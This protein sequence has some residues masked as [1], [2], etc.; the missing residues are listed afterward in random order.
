MALFFFFFLG[1]NFPTL[2]VQNSFSTCQI[3]FI[4][5]QIIGLPLVSMFLKKPWQSDENSRRTVNIRKKHKNFVNLK[6]QFKP[7][8]I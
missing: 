6:H 1:K 3:Y 8:E 4:F 7:L 2:D 5:T